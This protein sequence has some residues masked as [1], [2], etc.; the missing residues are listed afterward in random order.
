MAAA[1]FFTVDKG[2]IKLK[3][4]IAE[5]LPNEFYLQGFEKLFK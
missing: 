2:G 3:Y 4:S 1:P 5:E